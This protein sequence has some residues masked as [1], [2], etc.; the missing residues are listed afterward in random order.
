MSQ[1]PE[2]R[3]RLKVDHGG[4]ILEVDE[5][6]IEKVS[7]FIEFCTSTSTMDF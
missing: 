5:E 4:D 1:L 7:I 2:G 6:D 3:V